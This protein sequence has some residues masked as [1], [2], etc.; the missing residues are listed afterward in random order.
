[1]TADQLGEA[2]AEEGNRW[3]LCPEL[4]RWRDLP[5]LVDALPAGCWQ[6]PAQ[7]ARAR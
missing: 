4:L 1:M 6:G 3:P 5:E 7:P 2:Y